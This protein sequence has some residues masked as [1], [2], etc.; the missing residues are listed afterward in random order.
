MQFAANRMVQICACGLI[1]AWLLIFR[2]LWWFDPAHDESRWFLWQLLKNKVRPICT[3]FL[4][5]GA[6]ALAMRLMS[7]QVNE[8]GS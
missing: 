7:R 4:H 3:P 2:T 5:I 6:Q 8:P 1:V